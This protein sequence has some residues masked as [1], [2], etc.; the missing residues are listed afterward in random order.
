MDLR[1]AKTIEGRTFSLVGPAEYHAPEVVAGRG[2]TEASD[3]W[4]LGVLGYWMAVGMTPFA[5][6]GDDDLRISRRIAE[7]ASEDLTLP[8]NISDTLADLLRSL[9]EPDPSL[10]LGNTAGGV[11]NIKAHPFFDGIEWEYLMDGILAPP[12]SLVNLVDMW[13]NLMPGDSFS[14]WPYTGD[15]SW[16]DAF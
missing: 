11:R 6:A 8:P 4:S 2:A 1:F 12:P 15:T 7:H 14:P 13:N 9:M 16:L 3:W 5:R 10:R